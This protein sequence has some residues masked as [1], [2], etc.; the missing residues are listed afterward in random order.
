MKIKGLLIDLDGVIYNDSQPIPGAVDA[1]R[2]MRE[3]NIPFRFITNT[4]MKNREMLAAKLNAMGISAHPRDIFSAASAGADFLRQH[5]ENASFL[6]LTEEA[7]R[8]YTEIPRAKENARFVVVGDLGNDV[9]I[10][11][12]ND[13]FNCLMQGAQLVALQ[14]NRF[15]LSD[16][17][18]KM[19]AGAFVAMLEYAANVRAI[20]I[21]KPSAK[22]FDLALASLKLPAAE[23]L[24]IG[25][26]VE[27]DI[28]G[29]ARMGLKT[30]LVK[31]GKYRAIDLQRAAIQPQII[32]ESIAQLPELL[33]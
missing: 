11:L 1:I 21:G 24:M 2:F 4:T 32:L 9:S 15:W 25:D 26:D 20:L 33:A 13:A 12:L 14:K 27:S 7:K 3:R 18:Y 10:A 8:E 31:T 28:A 5:E 16:E 22:F 30:C 23:V 17:G 6:L 19:D 29:A